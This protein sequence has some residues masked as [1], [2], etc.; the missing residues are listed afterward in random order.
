MSKSDAR[1]APP[2]IVV[3]DDDASF[4]RA[5]GRLIGLWGYRTSSF[6]S[7]EEYLGTGV[8]TDCIVLDLHLE[9]MSGLELQSVLAAQKKSI[10]II[11]VSAMD[12]PVARQSALAGGA[13]AFLEKPFDDYSLLEVLKAVTSYPSS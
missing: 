5:V 1:T 2:L 13:A 7:A 3:V 10:P 12:D 6:S 9:G 4:R 8:E 11:F